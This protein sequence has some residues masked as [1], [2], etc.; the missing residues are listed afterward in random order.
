MPAVGLVTKGLQTGHKV[1]AAIN[2]IMLVT[3]MKSL[4]CRGTLP[5]WRR[6]H[7]HA[8]NPDHVEETRSQHT[9]DLD[10]GK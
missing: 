9:G 4:R 5:G 2:E 8:R 10:A 1:K 6:W 7:L 3:E